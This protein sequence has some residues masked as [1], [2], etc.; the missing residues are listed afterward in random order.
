MDQLTFDRS[1][2][3]VR[4][5]YDCTAYLY[6]DI[7]RYT[8]GTSATRGSMAPGRWSTNFAER[9]ARGGVARVAVKTKRYNTRLAFILL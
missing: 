5:L 7:Q 8:F 4:N 1:A 9:T 6:R 3:V 2:Y